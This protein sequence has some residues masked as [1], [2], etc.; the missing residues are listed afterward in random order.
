MCFPTPEEYEKQ[1][2]KNLLQVFTPGQLLRIS[3]CIQEIDLQGFGEIHLVF[4]E[5]RF[6]RVVTLRSDNL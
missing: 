1:A 4:K 5:G 3:E 6:R 2:L